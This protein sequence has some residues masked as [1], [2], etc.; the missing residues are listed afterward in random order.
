MREEA[1]RLH[2]DL[3]H[4]F[5]EH[6][7][8]AIS[9]VRVL[10]AL[11]VGEEE[12]TSVGLQFC[13]LGWYILQSILRGDVCSNQLSHVVCNVRMV[14]CKSV[15]ILCRILEGRIN[16][17]KVMHGY[18]YTRVTNDVHVRVYHNGATQRAVAHTEEQLRGRSRTLR[19]STSTEWTLEEITCRCRIRSPQDGETEV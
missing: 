4:S 12:G 15:E 16:V 18:Q 11:L 8:G 14:R 5:L 7:D 6:A 1:L 10:P 9:K 19:R 3:I 2:V 17:H 13:T